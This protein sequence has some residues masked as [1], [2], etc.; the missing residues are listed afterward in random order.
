MKKFLSLLFV[1][2]ITVTEAPAQNLILNGNFATGDFTGWTASG[3]AF[4]VVPSSF[5][6]TP[7][8][9][10]SFLAAADGNDSLSQSFA[11]MLGQNYT[12]SFVN[13]NSRGP[14]NQGGVFLRGL[15]NGS[16]LFT[17][18]T[19]L[20]NTSWVP[21]SYEFTATSSSTSLQLA[22]N[23]FNA[24]GDGL[25]DDISVTPTVTPEPSTLALSALGGVGG[26]VMY[27]RRKCLSKE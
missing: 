14:N 16:T 15:I 12:L 25:I 13:A 22:L 8:S 18:S 17:D 26:L 6:I 1:A 5:G 23:Y 20:A 2:A 9:G 3:V 7:L 27:R 11:T 10:D 4:S 24:N 19:D 21:S